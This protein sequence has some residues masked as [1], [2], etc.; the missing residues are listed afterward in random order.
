VVI[1]PLVSVVIPTYN[2]RKLLLEAVASVLEQDMDE[3][4][5]V[6]V[7]D[8][9]DDGT[10]QALQ[11]VDPRLR[12]LTQTRLLRGAA[13]NHGIR[14]ARGRH[15][16]FLDDDDRFEPWHLS[17]ALDLLGESTGV[18]VPTVLWDP[19]TGKKRDV[20]APPSAWK[21]PATAS[22]DGMLFPLQSLVVPRALALGCGGFPN[23]PTVDGS[24]DLVF[25]IRLTKLC[26]LRQA[27][28]HSVLIRQ[29]A[30]RGMNDL[31]YIIRSRKAATDLILHEGRAGQ[32]LTESE[33]RRLVA[34][35]HRF[36]A[37]LLYEKGSMKDARQELG[38][39][40]MHLPG[41]SGWRQTVPLQMQTYLGRTG[42][43]L[44]G[45]VKSKVVWK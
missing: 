15:I 42:S 45:Q 35:A 1:D 18:S 43:R 6:V 44:A 7:D 26:P 3:L 21:D 12:C 23:D 32:E 10:P 11:G 39:A 34:G 8:G 27:P 24:E 36:N 2:R 9:S 16:A 37:A 5:I 14:E 22:L 19:S 13:R 38:K 20:T 31:D 29:H 41:W 4:E 17:Q 33:R 28:R 40:R 30:E 25:L